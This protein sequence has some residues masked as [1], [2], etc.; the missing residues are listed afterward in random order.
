MLAMWNSPALSRK[1]LWVAQ[2]G[3]G[4]NKDAYDVSIALMRYGSTVGSLLCFSSASC[5]NVQQT[6]PRSCCCMHASG[7]V[8]SSSTKVFLISLLV[9]SSSAA[10]LTSICTQCFPC[11]DTFASYAAQH[12][13]CINAQT[14]IIYIPICEY[15]SPKRNFG[16]C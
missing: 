2:H 10:S 14:C 1:R 11:V 16:E 3:D 5:C 7:H 6:I 15:E 8:P 12:S 4:F 9:V 13:P